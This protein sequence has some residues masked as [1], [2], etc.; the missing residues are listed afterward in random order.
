[1]PHIPANTF[2]PNPDSDFAQPKKQVGTI[3]LTPT[4]VGVLPLL[5]AAYSE[6]T[7]HGRQLAYAE[8]LRMAKIADQAGER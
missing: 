5:L 7:P 8:L 3:D 1:M 4:W 6:G 2:D